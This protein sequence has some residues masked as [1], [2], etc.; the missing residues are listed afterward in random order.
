MYITINLYASPVNID[1]TFERAYIV[2]EKQDGVKQNCI[3][4]NGT[5]QFKYSPQNEWNTILVP[6]E[7]AMQGYAIQHD[8]P[9]FYKKA[10]DIP[11]EYKGKRII[12]RFDGIYS[13][14]ELSVNGK[15]VRTHQGGFT[16]WE[17]DITNFVTPGQKNEVSLQVTDPYN[18]ISYGSGY[19][20]HPIGGILRDVTLFALPK[21]Y[22][23]D[24]NIET[25]LSKPLENAVLQISC[26]SQS[27]S[28][29]E[30]RFK[31][32]SPDEQ[33][34]KLQQ[35][36]FPIQ[37]G[38]NKQEWQIP[39]DNPVLWDAEHPNL[40]TLNVITQKEGK[41]ISRFSRKIGLRKIELKGKQMYINNLPV[42]LRGAC[43]HD[44]HPTLGRS[45]TAELDSIDALMFKK[46]NMNFVRTTHYPPSENFLEYCDRYGIY[47]ECE[48]AICFATTSREKSYADNSVN[49]EKFTPQYLSQVREMV[50]SFRNHASI[51]I[52][53]IGNESKYGSNFLK[54]QQWIKEN[55]TTRPVIFSWPGLQ[56][57]GTPVY[58]ITSIHYPNLG[59]TLKQKGIPINRF[60]GIDK[61]VLFDE[62]IHPACYTYETLQRDPNIR[63]FW[64]QSIDKM[65]NTVFDIP[66]AL[67][68]AIWCYSDETFFLPEPKIGTA[69]W[70]EKA[71]DQ[72]PK[73]TIGNCVGYGE[74]GIVDIW[75]RV[76]P[77]FWATKKAY[78]P[79]RLLAKREIQKFAEN[80]QIALPVYNRFD[81]TNLN[82]PQ[83]FY[84]YNTIKKKIILP[85]VLPHQK[86]TITIP[87][88]NWKEGEN[89]C[90]EF[91]N[92]A[93]ELIDR[94]HFTLGKE[95]INFPVAT[96][97]GTLSVEETESFII[98]KGKNFEIPFSK[99]S[100]LIT[101]AKINGETFI[102]QG[103]FLNHFNFV[104]ASRKQPDVTPFSIETKDWVKTNLKYNEHTDNITVELS[105]T[106]KNTNVDF[107]IKITTDGTMTVDYQAT[108][109]PNNLLY[110]SGISFYISDRINKIDWKRNGYWCNY[111]ENSIAA[112]EG[113]ADLTYAQYNQY[114]KNNS[115]WIFDT[116]NYFYW[117]NAGSNCLNPLTNIAKGLKEYIYYYTL[118]SPQNKLSVTSSN[119]SIACRINRQADNNLVLYINNRWDYPD[120]AWGNYC[121]R[122][123]SLPCS[124]TVSIVLQ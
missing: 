43:R 109:I 72:K 61:P 42:K 35:H 36:T 123:K 88:E 4:L 81:H 82:E 10:F 114:G 120:I 75:R 15:Y 86:G 58:D 24:V 47:V 57:E 34:I 7:A 30:I 78:S 85:S 90:I 106:Y 76:K 2:P 89:L 62:W 49:N 121:T 16:R 65:W 26:T 105:G 6:G 93:N 40:Y 113:T 67:G 110:E 119:A 118:S 68:G 31:L 21:T 51:I 23:Y 5:W 101:D 98:L 25:K 83:A 1:N 12:L 9:F 87:A 18:E 94:Y 63:E 46:A 45:T 124:G 3:S 73:S 111:P 69:F 64:G 50:K 59:G 52:W 54:S 17:T 60:E 8:Q 117:G 102:K 22:L 56:K 92:K 103:P 115:S 20:H 29:S 38:T 55:D 28:S 14:A 80:E 19:A 11:Q 33:E 99:K 77:E 41:E 37:P 122:I 100:G 107:L 84:T 39:I 116:H 27:D 79:I 91:F 53:S 71:Y 32:T 104:K 97:K 48:T 95:K 66:G 44:M 112:N 70:K 74:W 96:V 13:L 108:G